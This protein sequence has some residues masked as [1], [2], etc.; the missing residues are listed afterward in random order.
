MTTKLLLGVVAP[1]YFY[2]HSM[3]KGI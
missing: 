3:N 2:K 1:K